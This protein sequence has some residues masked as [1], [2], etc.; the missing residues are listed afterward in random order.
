M[1]TQLEPPASAVPSP[2]TTT[3]YS[4]TM[5]MYS[6]TGGG[7]NQATPPTPSQWGSPYE[8]PQHGYLQHVVANRDTPYGYESIQGTNSIMTTLC[9]PSFAQQDQALFALFNKGTSLELIFQGVESFKHMVLSK[10][11]NG[12]AF[13][14]WSGNL[15]YLAIVATIPMEE[16]A[17]RALRVG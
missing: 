1:T 5:G 15:Q 2:G 11:F 16:L 14:A 8:F 7:S 13:A 9:S 3:E 6:S 4:P 10:N 12:L 17:G